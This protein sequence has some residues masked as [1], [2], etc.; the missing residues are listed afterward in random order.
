MA[1]DNQNDKPL[2]GEGGEKRRSS[3]LLPR[4]FRTTANVNFLQATLDQLKI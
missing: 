1:I 2:P 4:Y 3:D